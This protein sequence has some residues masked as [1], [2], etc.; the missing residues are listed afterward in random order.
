MV[1]VVVLLMVSMKFGKYLWIK[2]IKLTD[3][4][5]CNF[6]K[7]MNSFEKLLKTTELTNESDFNFH[8]N[9]KYFKNPLTFF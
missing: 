9:C 8:V 3:D 2:I 4:R 1:L 7:E 5:N 6:I